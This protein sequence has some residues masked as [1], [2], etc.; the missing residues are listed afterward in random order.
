MPAYAVLLRG[1]NVGGHR[2][3]PMTELRALLAEL[4]CASV[5]TYLRS[6]NAVGVTDL[7]PE[8]LAAQVH[9]ALA[10]RLGV[11]SDVLVRTGPELARVVGGCPWQGTDPAKLHVLFLSG[12]LAAAWRPTRPTRD[13]VE[14]GERCLYVDYAEGAGRATLALDPRALGGPVT[15]RNWRTVLALTE[16]VTSLGP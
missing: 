12:P 7:A 10:G 14:F 3:V 5:A 13:R 8:D 9:D 11:D 16:L 4:G 2:R 15:A 1:V 6:G